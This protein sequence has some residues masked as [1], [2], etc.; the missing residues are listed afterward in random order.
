[1]VAVIGALACEPD[2]ALLPAQPPD[3]VHEVAFVALQVRVLVC[4]LVTVVGLALI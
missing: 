3:A 1:V 4:P 2:S